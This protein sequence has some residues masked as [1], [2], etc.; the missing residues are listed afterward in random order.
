MSFYGR[1][2]ADLPR[3]RDGLPDSEVSPSF[4]SMDDIV[5]S[6]PLYVGLEIAPWDIVIGGSTWV[7]Q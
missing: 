4:V 2:T 5:G 7:R 6:N 1:F 3:S